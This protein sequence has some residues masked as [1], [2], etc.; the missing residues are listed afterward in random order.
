[1]LLKVLYHITIHCYDKEDKEKEKFELHFKRDL[2]LPVLVPGLLIRWNSFDEV[3][4][5]H[6]Y[7]DP[8]QKC[9]YSIFNKIIHVRDVDPHAAVTKQMIKGGWK[10]TERIK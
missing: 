1:M 10:A 8:E 9:Y 3:K 4:L 2:E 7:Y 6:Y 5:E